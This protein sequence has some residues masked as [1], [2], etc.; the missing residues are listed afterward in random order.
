MYH[1]KWEEQ[2]CPIEELPFLGQAPNGDTI[3][4]NSRYFLKNGKPWYPVMGEFHFSRYSAEDWERE[5]LKMKAGGVEIVASYI[6]WIHH[7]E[8][9]GVWNFDG[10]CDLRRFVTL[11][12]KH[13]LFV[14]LRVGPWAHGECR[15]G[16]LPDWL[17]AVGD[18]GVAL[19]LGIGKY[20]TNDPTYLAAVDRFYGKIAEEVRGLLWGESGPVIAI[21]VENEYY[22]CEP[23]TPRRLAH[24]MNLKGMLLRHGLRVPI[25]TAT[26]WNGGAVPDGEMLPVFGGYCDAPWADTTDELPENF[27]FIFSPALND[28]LIGTYQLANMPQ[29][30]PYTCDITRYPYLTAELGGG[31]QPTDLRRVVAYPQDAEAMAFCKIGSGANLLG[32]YMYH[33]G[34]NPLGRLS[35]MQES[36]ECF[37]PTDVPIRSYDFEAPLDE[38]GTPRESYDRTRRLHLFLHAWGDIVARSTT[39]LPSWGCHDPADGETPRVAVRHDAASGA[40]FVL[41]NNYQ[42]KRVL[43]EHK[44]FTLS[45][46]LPQGQFDTLPRDIPNGTQ[47]IIPY[48][49]PMGRVVLKRTNANPLTFIG[50]RYFFYT[51]DLPIYEFS[52]ATTEGESAGMDAVPDIITLSERDSRHA[53]RF[54]NKL[55][56]ADCALYE[57]EGTVYAEITKDTRVTVYAETG[58]PVTLFLEAPDGTYNGACRVEEQADGSYLLTPCY[59]A[60]GEHMLLIDY[61]GDKAYLYD[62]EGT[63]LSDWYTTG[64]PYCP[65]LSMLGNPATL[66]LVLT[67]D[68]MPRY[69]DI[70]RAAGCRLNDVRLLLRHTVEVDCC[71]E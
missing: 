10:N 48:Y 62:E 29:E 52:S 30:P 36:K 15:N 13:G 42:R 39:A 49:L 61:T 35:T 20:R 21:Q 14:C 37:Y 56:I 70:P 9:E 51:D 47:A 23:N 65:S 19:G 25:Y 31:M 16:G 57:K 64:L 26:G 8:E 38:W 6:F 34:T 4:V 60:E 68:D 55:Y 45:L 33:G 59:G 12:G 11:C 69:F 2:E 7:E 5:L 71:T 43:R 40:G 58:D 41:I 63:L 66:R 27:N 28:P 3:A 18:E 44:Q 22:R 67:D 32:Y 1:Y 17:R 54:G 46:D 24:M 50:N 53:Y